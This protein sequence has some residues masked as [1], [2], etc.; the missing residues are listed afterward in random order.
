MYQPRWRLQEAGLLAYSPTVRVPV[1]GELPLVQL[2]E[3]LAQREPSAEEEFYG[4]F[5]PR[6]TFLARRELRSTIDADD[7]A[8]ETLLRVLQSVRDGKLRVADAL[9]SF[10]WQ[11]ARNV[12]RERQRATRR[13][14]PIGESGSGQEPAAPDVAPPDPA[15]NAALREALLQLNRRDRVFLR[16]YYF[17]DL[18]KGDIARRLGIDEA[19]V[20]LVKSRALQRF[21]DAYNKVT[22][23]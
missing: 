19:R 7:I 9:P 23:R 5:G 8:S 2:V 20:R 1:T 12:I 10:V 6:V 16:L 4:R 22:R 21:R 17:D 18:P 15:A 11:T 14:V 13:F 3:R